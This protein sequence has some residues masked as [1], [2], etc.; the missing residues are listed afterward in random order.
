MADRKPDFWGKVEIMGHHVLWGHITEET[1]A[2]AAFIRVDVPECG[3]QP[4]FSKLFGAAAIFGITPVAEDLVRAM[5]KDRRQ[6]P[7]DVYDLP[8]EWRNKISAR[9]LP[10]PDPLN[11]PD[12]DEPM[13]FDDV[14]DGDVD[15]V[16]G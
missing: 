3:D 8:E 12:G 15:Q 9:T 11:D 10:A 6:R 7:F 5:V 2:G 13:D 14:D 16:I 1:L 4:A